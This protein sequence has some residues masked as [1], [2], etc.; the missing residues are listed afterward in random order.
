M[1]YRLLRED[2]KIKS[3]D[4]V[5]HG[6]VWNKCNC[7]VGAS[8]MASIIRRQVESF[9]EALIPDRVIQVTAEELGRIHE[10]V[11]IQYHKTSTLKDNDELATIMLKLDDSREAI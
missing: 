11:D 4:D 3:G 1:N 6:N 10:C 2:E 7:C 8:V 5:L 9:T